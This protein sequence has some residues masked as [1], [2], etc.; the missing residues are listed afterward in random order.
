MCEV[1][2]NVDE[3]PAGILASTNDTV[4]I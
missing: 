3:I 1:C 4:E 2:T